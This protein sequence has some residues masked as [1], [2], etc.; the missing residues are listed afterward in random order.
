VKEARTAEYL[1]HGVLSSSAPTADR[2]ASGWRVIHVPALPLPSGMFYR[3]SVAAEGSPAR[4]CVVVIGPSGRVDA[5]LVN[6]VSTAVN[7][8]LASAGVVVVLE[9]GHGVARVEG[10]IAPIDMAVAVAVVKYAAGWDDSTPMAIQAGRESLLVHLAR[11]G[12]RHECRV[13]RRAVEQ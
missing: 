12:D 2:N 6:Q 8:V 9:D 1:E 13:E 3:V 11:Q 7:A 4:E 5:T 10:S